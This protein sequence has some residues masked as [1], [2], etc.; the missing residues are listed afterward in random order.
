MLYF[1]RPV[2]DISPAIW[3]F[4]ALFIF[5]IMVCSTIVNEIGSLV[6]LME[7]PDRY[8]IRIQYRW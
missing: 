5:N 4:Y 3:Q 6:E 2:M 8:W 1:D 7:R